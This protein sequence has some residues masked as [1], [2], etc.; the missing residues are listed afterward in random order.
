MSLLN[1]DQT[2]YLFNISSFINTSEYRKYVDNVLKVELGLDLYIRVPHCY[3]A[4]FREIESLEITTVAI[5]MKCQKGIDQ[6]YS[7]ELS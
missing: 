5:F 3:K 7:K 1:H 4:F 2:L 6:L